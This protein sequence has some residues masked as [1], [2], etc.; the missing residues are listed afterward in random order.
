MVVF[1]A[2]LLLQ[3]PPDVTVRLRSGDT[4]TGSIE[5][6]AS[7]GTVTLAIPKAGSRSVL[8][9]ELDFIEVKRGSAR[10]NKKLDRLDLA[11]SSP[12]RQGGHLI[13]TLESYR[14]GVFSFST[15][16]G[17][18][19]IPRERVLRVRLGRGKGA[20][21]PGEGDGVATE[22]ETTRGTLASIDDEFVTMN[23]GEGVVKIARADAQ[24]VEPAPAETPAEVA[25]G[26]YARLI[27]AQGGELVGALNGYRDGTLI[28]FS[29]QVGEVAV[30]LES[31]LQV[32]TQQRL[33]FQA[34]RFLLSNYQMIQEFE[35][36]PGESRPKMVWQFREARL[37]YANMIKK[38]PNGNVMVADMNNGMVFE[39]RP[40]PGNKGE[41]VYEGSGVSN[42][43]DVCPLGNGRYWVTEMGTG[44]IVEL[45]DKGER[46]REI[47][48]GGRG[49]P[50]QLAALPGGNVLVL[51]SNQK[52]LEM[53]T[54]DEVV[55]E[56]SVSISNPDKML[57]LD[58]G[59]ILLTSSNQGVVQE[60][61]PDGKKVWEKS[62]LSR[63]M[64]AARLDNGNTLVAEQGRNQLVEY[65]A[66]GNEARVHQPR[67][68]GYMQS[69]SYY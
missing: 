61:T 17:D 66:Q 47:E 31:L 9:E 56:T 62:G 26:L 27:L 12:L 3:D 7:D 40:E 5:S 63:P 39:I 60:V 29:P 15:L 18:F 49:T 59:N 1:I 6:V 20:V 21:K 53:T 55:R 65:D 43:S 36:Q 38:L 13:G 8:L 37:Q 19:E 50:V 57:M 58:N 45:D 30:P 42:P 46:A 69:L 33:S 24:F 22:K 67:E 51:T 10:I 2:A 44:K 11:S 35:I 52:L 64:G 54:D 25:V 68:M 16:L 32:Q 4:L 41:I 28:V 23:V 34:G 14:D 48:T